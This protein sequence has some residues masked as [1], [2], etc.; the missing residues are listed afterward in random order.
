[1]LAKNKFRKVESMQHVL[2]TL[3]QGKSPVTAF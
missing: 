3:Q 1:V 2:A